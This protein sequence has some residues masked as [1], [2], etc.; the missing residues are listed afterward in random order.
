MTRLPDPPTDRF[1]DLV[2]KGGITSGVVYPKAIALLS[3]H[4]YFKSIGGTSAGAIAA[5][6]TAAAEYQRRQTGSRRGFDLLDQLPAELQTEVG[7]GKRK[8]LSLFQPQP[9]TR[10]L[11]TVLVNAL[12]CKTT[13]T[14]LAKIIG[15]LL[16]A[17]WPA[18][19]AS[20]LIAL[21]V[22]AAGLG[23]LGAGLTLLGLLLAT[24]AGWVY[25][26]I[27]RRVVANGYGIC[28]GMTE[29]KAHV[30][31]TPWLHARIQESCGRT[32]HD[33]PLTFGDLWN[34]NGLPDWLTA[35]ARSAMRSID[36]QVFSTNL[37]HGRPY[38]FPLA[39]TESEA[40]RFRSRERL[41]FTE[42]EMKRYLPLDVVQWMVAKSKPYVLEEGREGKD[43]P[44]ETAEGMRELPAPKDFPVLLAARMSLAFP[45]LFTAIPLHAIDHDPP[46]KR[47][48][49]RC[50]FTDG[51]ISSNF[52]IH[53][54]D[55]YFPRWP[56]FGISLE[57]VIEKRPLSLWYLPKKY[58]EGYGE[59]WSR[60]AENEKSA[61]K[62]GGFVSAIFNAMQNWN[63]NSLA[64]MPG[65]R[66]RIARVR[67]HKH[68]G[69]MNLNME[70]HHINSIAERGVAAAQELIERFAGTSYAGNQ[71]SGWDEH[72]FVRI[73]LFLKLL[74]EKIP[75]T[76]MAMGTAY[77]H[78]TNL[79]KLFDDVMAAKNEH[80]K[81]K[82]PP[83]YENVLTD[84]Q[85]KTLEAL[86]M[87]LCDL[88]KQI[89][90]AEQEIAF[91]AIPK[92]DLRIRPPL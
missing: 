56:T 62:L 35:S 45:L 77:P 50:W 58:E 71:A 69:G 34:A 82:M 70:A 46:D 47:S 78:A 83:G 67:L 79:A 2:M 87:A 28:T 8:L 25:F 84:K 9:G 76:A 59:R 29:D 49:R 55:S 64:R 51:G 54:F 37:A 80:G 86:V 5:V 3:R 65:V 43:P 75:L 15:G 88:A 53:L 16:I 44:A 21:G 48:F 40:S 89:D 32:P 20:F 92:S 66:D 72:R 10:R 73:N 17:Y 36:L 90:N 22:G 60:F 19:L 41:Y 11:F 42:R 52:P 26:D 57:P 63:D 1:C 38:I 12:N 39:E 85:R 14:R 68:E 13:N 61:S 31:L 81:Q 27:S 23:W 7:K 91:K 74:E 24:I 4:Y 18:T 6:L 33:S 30:A